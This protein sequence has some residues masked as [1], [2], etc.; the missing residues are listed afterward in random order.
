MKSKYTF[1]TLLFVAQLISTATFA[2]HQKMKV[3]S[4]VQN[5]EGFKLIIAEKDSETEIL[6]VVEIIELKA[7]GS[8]EHFKIPKTDRIF[9]IAL[10]ISGEIDKG[11]TISEKMMSG[12]QILG[13]GSMHSFNLTIT[14]SEDGIFHYTLTNVHWEHAE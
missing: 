13:V 8:H 9:V 4:G 6:K 1:L 3:M 14:Q 11:E 12:V 7:F 5:E 10:P 2:Q